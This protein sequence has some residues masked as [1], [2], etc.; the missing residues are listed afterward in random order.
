MKRPTG[1]TLLSLVLGWLTMAGIGNGWAV[2]SGSF[3]PLPPVLGY[4]ALAYAATAFTACLGLWRMK[5]W[6]LIALRSWMG[7]CALS[8]I[9]FMYIFSEMVLG[10]SLG[11]L[12]FLAFVGVL[13]WL[14]HRYVS[15]KF[16]PVT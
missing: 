9:V 8:L 2:L 10:G 1:I 15:S 11:G 14:L 3:A 12:G 5:N 13:F 7:V 4:L 6:G 16:N